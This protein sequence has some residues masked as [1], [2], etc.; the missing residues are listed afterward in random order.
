VSKWR[1]SIYLEDY[2]NIVLCYYV[3]IMM[4]DRCPMNE[5]RGII[6]FVNR[7]NPKGPMFRG[8]VNA[9]RPRAVVS[10][11]GMGICHVS[12]HTIVML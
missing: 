9:A 8:M 11:S 3:P 7:S 5:E 4:P 10:A 12:M 2:V 6:I 1:V